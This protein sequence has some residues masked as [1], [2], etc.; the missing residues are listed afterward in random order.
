MWFVLL[1]DLAHESNIQNHPFPFFPPIYKNCT[2]DFFTS[3]FYQKPSRSLW[4]LKQ[5]KKA[6][7][8]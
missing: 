8:V 5:G 7:L 6:I 1:P 4:G 2:M 3:Y